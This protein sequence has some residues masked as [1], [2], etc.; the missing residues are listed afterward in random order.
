METAAAP[1]F[2]T[3][4]EYQPGD[5][6]GYL[7]RRILAL[8]TAEVD[9]RLEASGLTSAQWLPLLKLHTGTAG[10]VAELAREC[11]LDVGA[12][13]RLLDR[14]EGKG[15]LCRRRSS[16]DRRVVNLV[17]T[18]AGRAAAETIPAVVCSVENAY[19]AGFT[20]AEWQQLKSL[21]HSVLGN[22]M[23]IRSEKGSQR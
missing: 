9:R 20:M 17:L 14:L 6:E 13:T 11:Q 16:T 3:A 21:L 7:M 12:M 2:Y 10:S 4:A 18:D 8:A 5:S 23:A 15:L 19:L 1:I 22:A